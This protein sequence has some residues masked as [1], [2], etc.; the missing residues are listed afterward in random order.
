MLRARVRPP[1]ARRCGRRQKLDP[2]G[3][4]AHHLRAPAPAPAPSF[5]SSHGDYTRRGWTQRTRETSFYQKRLNPQPYLVHTEKES[6]RVSGPPSPARAPRLAAAGMRQFVFFGT[7]ALQRAC[8]RVFRP[9][10]SLDAASCTPE[11]LAQLSVTLR[12]RKKASLFLPKYTKEREGGTHAVW[13]PLRVSAGDYAGEAAEPRVV[14]ERR[15]APIRGPRARKNT[16]TQRC[17]VP[18]Y[19]GVTNLNTDPLWREREKRRRER[20]DSLNEYLLQT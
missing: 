14:E 15:R 19:V 20:G 8:S 13:V 7:G 4:A 11:S 12:V 3:V 17:R 10:G 18:G 6:A 16:H 2:E 5:S 9:H 1:E